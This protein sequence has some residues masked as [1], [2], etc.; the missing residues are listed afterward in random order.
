MAGWLGWMEEPSRVERG[1]LESRGE[2]GV[3]GT[4]AEA[5]AAP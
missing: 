4:A 2:R 3:L 1:L 5:V